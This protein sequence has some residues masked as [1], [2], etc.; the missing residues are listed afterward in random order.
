MIFWHFWS[1]L[2]VEGGSKLIQKSADVTNALN[3]GWDK[4]WQNSILNAVE[5]GPYLLIVAIGMV[6][7]VP[8]LIAYFYNYIFQFVYGGGAVGLSYAVTYM[9][10]VVLLMAL[11]SGRGE[12]LGKLSY[13][14]NRQIL[15]FNEKLMSVQVA[16]VSADD[17]IKSLQISNSAKIV[18]KMEYDKCLQT[19]RELPSLPSDKQATVEEILNL[20]P[21]YKCFKDLL[22]VK[23]AAIKV[24]FEAQ[25]CT[26]LKAIA[27][28]GAKRS[29][30]SFAN[31]LRAA[32]DN[33]KSDAVAK[34]IS[35]LYESYPGS[36]TAKSGLQFGNALGNYLSGQA[37]KGD[38]FAQLYSS[39]VAYMHSLVGCLYLLGL[40]APIF[41]GA[42]FYPFSPRTCWVWLITFLHVGLA[43][44]TYSV[45][46]GASA[47]ALV[48][49]KAETVTDLQYAYMLGRF[50]PALS[51]GLAFF[52]AWK[53]ASAAH[54]NG[55]AIA[56]TAVSVTSSVILSAIRVL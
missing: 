7:A 30:D 39:Q 50:A 15:F 17:A 2:A 35:E 18:L 29:F 33:I 51:G 8:G 41:I 26:G 24:S 34:G 10:V 46:I 1:F 54:A 55:Q 13:G 36:A 23:I 40:F 11:F 22:N 27:C 31:N 21:Q 20:D 32:L 43:I 56:S 48:E 16:R 44:V 14:L 53:A 42:S 28:S 6:I 3:L 5:G 47:M 19:K 4:M 37:M 49:A 12:T 38:L 52:S 45:L 25:N 9:L